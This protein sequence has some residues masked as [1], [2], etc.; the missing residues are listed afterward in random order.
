[1]RDAVLAARQRSSQR[2]FY[3]Q[4]L[5]RGP[6]GRVERFGAGVLAAVSPELPERS[7]PN[8][9]LYEDP[10]EVV[11]ALD[12]LA[13][14][15]KGAGVRAWTVWVRPGDALLADRLEAAGH[16]HDGWPMLMGARLDEL[17]LGEPDDELELAPDP[18]W[19]L[20]G[21]INDAAWGVAGE[22]ER[23]LAA[24]EDEASRRWVACLDGRPC[25]S[26]LV[27]I[28]DGDAYVGL[29]A[30]M[31]SA[32]GRGLTTRLM[33]AALR[34]ARDEGCET[35]TLEASAMGEG[36]YAR[37]GYRSL[38]RFGLWERRDHAASA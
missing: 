30:T 25:A 24:V 11:A 6:G 35:T 3:E 9:V 37:M 20:V 32:R 1:M 18:S 12:G 22:F 31:P 7:L 28:A 26:V 14:A 27:R 8:G 2:G 4:V 17:D 5:A 15:Y 33:A 36:L 16:R 21:S 19:G 34:A 10:D 23:G 29:V 13:G 38:G